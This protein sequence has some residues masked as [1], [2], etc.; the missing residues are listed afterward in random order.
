[1]IDAELSLGES[2]FTG[3]PAGNSAVAWDGVS[4]NAINM[5]PGQFGA[6]A[7][8]LVMQ[9]VDAFTIGAGIDAIWFSLASRATLTLPG[10]TP[11][12]WTPHVQTRFYTAA[13]LAAGNWLDPL[14]VPPTAARFLSY[15]ASAS[16][17]I[18]AGSI[19][20]YFTREYPFPYGMQLI[21]TP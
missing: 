21:P 9:V 14:L 5:G 1:M 8:Y 4:A 10:T 19:R 3:L 7:L 17:A 16:A 2:D 20:A 15:L 18:T 6:T 12:D 13:E 11:E